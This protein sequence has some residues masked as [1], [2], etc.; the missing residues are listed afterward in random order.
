M[1][2]NDPKTRHRL[3]YYTKQAVR[4]SKTMERN[5]KAIVD[6]TLAKHDAGRITKS[7]PCP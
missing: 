7:G 5:A 3:N 2:T 4:N 6:K 1:D